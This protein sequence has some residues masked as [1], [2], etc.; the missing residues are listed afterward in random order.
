MQ[1]SAF[2]CRKNFIS[3]L[4]ST[5]EDLT[6]FTEAAI[7][8]VLVNSEF[9]LD[10]AKAVIKAWATRRLWPKNW[11]QILVKTFL[12]RDAVFHSRAFVSTA[13]ALFWRPGFLSSPSRPSLFCSLFFCDVTSQFV[14]F[15]LSSLLFNFVCGLRILLSCWSNLA[16]IGNFKHEK[17][18]TAIAKTTGRRKRNGMLSSRYPPSPGTGFHFHWRFIGV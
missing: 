12:S 1:L 11:R 15:R 2:S 9:V 7:G 17:E 3:D 14:V 4:R 6:W 16:K 5:F 8:F 13:S 10:L 18:T